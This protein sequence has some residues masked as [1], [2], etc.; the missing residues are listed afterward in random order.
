MRAER[1]ARMAEEPTIDNRVTALEQ[2]AERHE[3]RIT[4]HGR[5]IDDIKEQ[6]ILEKAEAHH[7]DEAVQR[8]ESKIDTL[9]GKVDSILLQPA[10]K[11]NSTTKTVIAV[12]ATSL[13]T[14]LLA[15]MG[16]S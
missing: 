12:V 7:R 11:W 14:L 10:E 3:T 9:G 2:T 5:E 8:T 13:V 1:E 16:L 15:R 6:L 4:T